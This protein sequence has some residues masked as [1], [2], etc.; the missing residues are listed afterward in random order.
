MKTEPRQ[1]WQSE[2]FPG[3][4]REVLKLRDDENFIAIDK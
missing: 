1:H 4:R 2:P 3:S